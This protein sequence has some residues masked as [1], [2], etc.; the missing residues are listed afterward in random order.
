MLPGEPLVVRFLNTIWAD[1]AGRHDDLAT[2][3]HLAAFLRRAVGADLEPSSADLQ[4]AVA[5]RDALRRLAAAA[6]ANGRSRAATGTDLAKAVDVVNRQLGRGVAG[7]RLELDPDGGLR[8]A[9]PDPGSVTSALRRL[10]ADALPLLTDPASALRSC[11][12]P[13]CVLYFVRDHPRRAWCSTACGNRAR[14]DRHYHRHHP[15]ATSRSPRPG[16]TPETRT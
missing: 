6:T 15:D 14:A 1:R 5:L 3:A 9:P 11:S 8:A 2:S 12:A 13:G 7:P 10:A 16:S 4:Q